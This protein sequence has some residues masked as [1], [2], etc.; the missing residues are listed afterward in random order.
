MLE[1]EELIDKT[2]LRPPS[3]L[4]LDIHVTPPKYRPAKLGR[5]K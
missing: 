3:W 1:K 2:L 4:Y 5:G